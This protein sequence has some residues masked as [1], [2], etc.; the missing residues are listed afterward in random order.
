MTYSCNC[1]DSRYYSVCVAEAGS[2]LG[3]YVKRAD[4]PVMKYIDGELSGP[5][6]NSFFFDKE[7][8]FMCAFHAHTYYDKPSG[9]RRFC[10]CPVEFDGRGALKL[11]YK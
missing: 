9:N 5:G 7:G 8:R 6:H 3:P 4:N 11:L 2:P 10:Y 1:F